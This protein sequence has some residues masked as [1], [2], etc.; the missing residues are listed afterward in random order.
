M[1]MIRTLIAG[2]IA[3]SALV[4]V[5]AH[6][7][8]TTFQSFVGNYQVST[9]GFG[10]TSQSGVISADEHKALLKMRRRP[11]MRLLELQTNYGL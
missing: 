9:D 10:S 2:A 5:S 3:A 8:L 1:K 6:A 4:G 7:S 11:L